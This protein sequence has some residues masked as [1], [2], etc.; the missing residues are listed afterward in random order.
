MHDI[1]SLE[2]INKTTWFQKQEIWKRPV[3][4]IMI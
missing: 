2:E 1:K 4:E 3:V